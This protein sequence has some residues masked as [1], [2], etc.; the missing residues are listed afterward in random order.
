[1]LRRPS[2]PAA[3]TGQV[4]V[5]QFSMP[6]NATNQASGIQSINTSALIVTYLVK[7]RTSGLLS[8]II[9]VLPV[10]LPQLHETLFADLL[11]SLLRS[12][13]Q[14]HSTLLQLCY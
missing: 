10:I 5:R 7:L 4:P 2:E 6:G 9:S 12:S 14:G 13:N 1:V 3:E 8:G 11:Q